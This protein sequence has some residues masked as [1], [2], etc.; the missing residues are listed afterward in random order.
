MEMT[1]HGFS[2]GQKGF[3]AIFLAGSGQERTGIVTN[4]SGGIVMRFFSDTTGGADQLRALRAL[5][6]PEQKGERALADAGVASSLHLVEQVF[7]LN[8]TQLAEVCGRVTRPAVYAW[9]NGTVPRALNLARIYELRRAALDW[10]RSGFG[11][12][13]PALHA[14]VI[15]EKSLFDLLRADPLDF[16]ALHFAGGR[17]A[18]KRELS[19]K[20]KLADPFR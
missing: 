2:G 18:L 13:G 10:K 16:E 4:G 5:P 20:R 17:I 7:D 8:T 6:E 19:A 14:P 9:R 12:P 3:V 1:Q 11:A 15:H